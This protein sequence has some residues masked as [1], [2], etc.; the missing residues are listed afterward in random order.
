MSAFR[1]FAPWIVLVVGLMAAALS[2][3]GIDARATCNQLK[4]QGVK[5]YLVNP[6]F[7]P[8]DCVVLQRDLQHADAP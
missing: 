2:L 8:A 5:A 1:F 3:D 6:P 4:A 7:G